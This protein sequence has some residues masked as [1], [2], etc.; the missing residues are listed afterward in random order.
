AY[1]GSRVGVPDECLAPRSVPRSRGAVEPRPSGRGLVRQGLTGC[2]KIID[3]VVNSLTAFISRGEG[4]VMRRG[5][6]RCATV[7]ALMVMMLPMGS[8]HASDS[9]SHQQPLVG[10]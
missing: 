8:A 2:V 1:A 5:V 7:L 6:K 3:K 4:P 9:D 10:P